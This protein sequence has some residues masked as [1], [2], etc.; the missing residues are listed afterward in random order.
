M[1]YENVNNSHRLRPSSASK[2]EKQ[3]P[4]RQQAT[5]T[6]FIKARRRPYGD[7]QHT[8]PW[9]LAILAYEQATELEE[10][11][12]ERKLSAQ[13]KIRFQADH[14]S[15]REGISLFSFPR[16][17]GGN[18]KEHTKWQKHNSSATT[19]SSEHGALSAI[20]TTNTS[21]A[22]NKCTNIIGLSNPSAPPWERRAKQGKKK[23]K[24]KEHSKQAWQTQKGR[25]TG[26][27][28]FPWQRSLAA[29]KPINEDSHFLQGH[30]YLCLLIPHEM[31]FRRCGSACTLFRAQQVMW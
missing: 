14:A 31:S 28:L 16:G 8:F 5:Q 7:S 21:T 10:E 23:R 17:G 18:G 11:R 4:W 26:G 24:R 25:E 20:T 13:P 6:N 27:V 3:D 30:H 19:K 9:H 29:F 1:H 2:T 12:S 15:R 22:N